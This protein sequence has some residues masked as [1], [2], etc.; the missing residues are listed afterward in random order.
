MLIA[1]LV[2]LLALLCAVLVTLADYLDLRRFQAER[3]TSTLPAPT[4]PGPLHTY[5][6]HPAARQAL[7]EWMA[8]PERAGD[9]FHTALDRYPLESGPWLGLAR[10]EASLRGEFSPTLAAN[11]AAAVA[12]QPHNRATRWRAA[13][14]ALHAADQDLAE[15]HLRRWVEGDARD[16]AQALFIA[17]RW[18]SEPEALLARMVPDSPE[19]RAEAMDFAFR[20]RDRA[21]AE[22]VWRQVASEQTLES[23]LFL[24]YADFLLAEGE[25]A[26]AVDLWAELDRYFRPGEI[27]NGDFSRELGR[28]QGLN[29]RIN[30]LPDGVRIERD[31][32]EHYYQPASLKIAFLGS[33]NLRLN[34]PQIRIPVRAGARYELSGFWQARAL[35][36]RARPYIYLTATS[37]RLRERIDPPR[38]QFGWTRFSSEFQVPESAQML[39]LSVRRDPTDAFDR[40]IDGTLWLDGFRLRELQDELPDA[41]PDASGEPGP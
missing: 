34:A 2:G 38:E 17:R 41:S 9:I 22:A 4:G 18:I 23:E 29:W 3:Q 24:T 37:G 40:Y 16:L 15:F 7:R 5:S 13:Q 32:S 14:I 26:R 21:L 11:L 31:I 20:Q 6:I 28:P 8:M 39:V 35:T 27:A 30:R 19:H 25:I 1:R 10:M 12:V 33:H 36:T